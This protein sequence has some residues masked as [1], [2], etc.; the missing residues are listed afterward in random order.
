[1]NSNG[2]YTLQHADINATS[3]TSVDIPKN[4]EYFFNYVSF[5]NGSV[6]VE[7]QSTKWDIAWTYFSNV[8]DFGGGE[9]PYAFQD[10]IVQNRNVKVAKVLTA[11]K[12]YETFSE[13]DI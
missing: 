6:T 10:F 11:D 9:V 4:T 13:S 5:E 3:F 8:T 1:R 12:S 7:P 2:G